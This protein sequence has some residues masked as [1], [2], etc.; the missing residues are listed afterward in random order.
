MGTRFVIDGDVAAD[1]IDEWLELGCL[2]IHFEVHP[3]MRELLGSGRT[4]GLRATDTGAHWLLDLTGDTIIW[5]RTAEAATADI[6]VPVADLL[7]L[8]YRRRSVGA[9]GIEVTG[10]AGLVDFW[11]ERVGFG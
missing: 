11:L 5:R 7:L 6:R 3:Q 9:D 1:G 4:V 10:D 8:I 2:P